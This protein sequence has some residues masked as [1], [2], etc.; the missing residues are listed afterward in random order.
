M[1]NLFILLSLSFVML[2]CSAAAPAGKLEDWTLQRAGDAKTYQV[3][4]PCTVAG[5]LNEAGVFGQDVL[6]QDRYKDIDKSIFD[7]PW[8]YTTRF[9]A[10]KGLCHVLR[11]EGLNFYA[12]IEL[13][14]Q[15]IASADTC[16]GTFSVR[17]LDI[18]PLARKDNK[19]KVT[20]RR[21]QSGDLNHGYVDWNP[22]ALDESM[23]IIRPVF[24]ISTPDVQVQDVFVNP[25]LD[26]EDFSSARLL[27]RTTLVNRSAQPVEGEVCGTFEG[28]EFTLP[29]QL[30]AG[31]TRQVTAQVEVSEPRI[32]WTAEMG[33]PEL[34]HMDVAFRKGDAV[35]HHKQVRFGIRS[36]TAEVDAAGHRQFYLNG[37]PV[38]IKAGGWTDDL[39]MQ[40]TP[41]DYEEQ[42]KMTLDM[43]LNCI[44][45]EN[46]W[47][48]DET[49]YDLCDSLGVLALVGWSCQWEWEDYCGLKE[50]RGYGCI[51]DPRSEAFAVRYF[52]DQVVRLRNHP[53]LIGWLTGSDRIPN[54]RL[55]GQYLAIYGKEDYRPYV[56]SAKGLT[57][58]GGPSGMKMEGPYEYVGPD[59]WWVDTQFGGAFGFNTETGP[60]LNM[61]QEESLRQMLGQENLWPVNGM[62][63]YHCTA[64][65]S[66]MN[67]TF[68]LEKVMKGLYGEAEDFQ[69]YMRKAHALDYDAT[70]SMFEAF[71]GNVPGATGIVMW[72]LNSAWPSLYW[73]FYDWYDV[74]TAAYF[75]TKTANRPLQLVFNYADGSVMSVNDA[76]PDTPAKARLRV[77]AADGKTLLR[78]ETK[79]IE[80]RERQPEKVFTGIAGPCFVALSLNGE[81]VNF[82]C[83]PEKG[84]RYDFKHADW[85]GL[86]ILEYADMRF[87]SRL[88][89]AAVHM[90]I[91]NAGD[92]LDVT[93]VNDSDVI[94][95]QNILK[96]VDTDGILFPGVVWSDN[97]VTLL[98]GETRTLHCSLPV[99]SDFAHI[100]LSGWNI[101]LK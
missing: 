29:V 52:R 51:N 40:D 45:F 98:P 101:E 26:P 72:M 7:E 33:A 99:G 88:P 64:S 86:D 74:P 60:G 37:R 78:D 4:V 67:N 59:Y 35:S 68:F 30:E 21:A 61:P 8:V 32:W 79:S 91:R 3:K 23:G 44:R 15:L 83:I 41:E 76:R 39:F 92:G 18:T 20:V 58:L 19:L 85:W 2:G 87:V 93:L 14:G 94:A 95:F 6:D 34:Y 69:D 9:Q 75:G 47:C 63:N 80:L 17:E 24:L 42:V 31:Q 46:I 16:N 89:K 48:K 36:I 1:K 10:E 73:Q 71:R 56:C 11:F 43:G 62:W 28:G 81:P 22:R 57:S 53:A 66:H 49:V 84:N 25:Q 82:Y 50:T 27:V 97:F 70:R 13:N 55:E 38:L 65:A 96:A 54:Q 5:A 12:D 100:G 77:F 90:E